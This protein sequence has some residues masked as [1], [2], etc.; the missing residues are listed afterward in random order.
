MFAKSAVVNHTII[1]LYRLVPD[2]Y[3][4]VTGVPTIG[5]GAVSVT[6]GHV[7]VLSAGARRE[8][9]LPATTLPSLAISCATLRTPA[10]RSRHRAHQGGRWLRAVPDA[11]AHQLPGVGVADARE[12]AS[13]RDLARRRA[14]GR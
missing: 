11:H 7:C 3:L 1:L 4:L 8:L 6:G 12:H 2:H 9:A 10:R 5:I 13:A 14:G